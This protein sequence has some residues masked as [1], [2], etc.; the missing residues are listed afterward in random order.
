MNS[1]LLDRS[2]FSL[3]EPV[4][5]ALWEGLNHIGTYG[6][7]RYEETID[8]C[9]NAEIVFTNKVIFDKAIIDQLPSL[10]TLEYTAAGTNN[11]DVEYAKTKNI[12]V[13]NVAG[14]STDSVAQHTLGLMLNLCMGQHNYKELSLW[15]KSPTFCRL[16][17][18][19]FQL[20]NKVLGIIGYG[21]I[22]REVERLAG[23]RNEN[24]YL[25]VLFN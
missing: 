23:L 20:K 14:Y 10:N 16:D 17:H 6:T 15:P 24:T 4:I 25:P 21:T 12:V 8:R 11:V 7:T 19:I 13:K 5:A 18:P 9:Q 22:G 1:V 2:T 3:P